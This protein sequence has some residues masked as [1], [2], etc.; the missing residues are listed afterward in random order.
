MLPAKLLNA[1][2]IFL[3]NH[4]GGRDEQKTILQTKTITT[5]KIFCLYVKKKFW[6]IFELRFE[7]CVV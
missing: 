3:P 5:S 1:T 2:T 7:I 4:R 6:K